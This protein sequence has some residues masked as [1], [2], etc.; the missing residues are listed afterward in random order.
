[1]FT[2]I[3]IPIFLAGVL[4]L[5]LLGGCHHDGPGGGGTM[6]SSSLNGSSSQPQPMPSRPLPVDGQRV[7]SAIARLSPENTLARLPRLPAPPA[8]ARRL[9]G[10]AIETW[11]QSGT[12][13]GYVRTL[14]Y[15]PKSKRFWI[16]ENG[17]I[18]GRTHWYGPLV[19]DDQAAI[20]IA[21]E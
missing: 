6:S 2:A 17:G 8:N 5:P 14:A 4:A 1:M 12:A 3:R 16:V 10:A 11:S 19:L 9:A 15:D 21:P 18:A 20:R 13:D 7:L